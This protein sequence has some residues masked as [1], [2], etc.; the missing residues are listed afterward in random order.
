MN[1]RHCGRLERS[2]VCDARVMLLL[3]NERKLTTL[4]QA[5]EVGIG[6]AGRRESDDQRELLLKAGG[7]FCHC[8]RCS[9]GAFLF[10]ALFISFFINY[11]FFT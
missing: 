3:L 9:V 7:C 8:S 5:G 11:L 10:I 4:W 6:R 1:G 2:L